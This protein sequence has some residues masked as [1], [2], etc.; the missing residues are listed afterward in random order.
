[1]NLFCEFLVFIL[2]FFGDF[3]DFIL[4]SFVSLLGFF[5][6]FFVNFL[7]DVSNLINVCVVGLSD[8]D[9]V[10]RVLLGLGLIKLLHDR[11]Q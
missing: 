8:C 9:V 1:L 2:M 5:V 10:F 3:L 6:V 4:V 7:G 11:S